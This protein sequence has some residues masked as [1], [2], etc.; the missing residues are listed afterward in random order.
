M[1]DYAVNLFLSSTLTIQC[2]VAVAVTLRVLGHALVDPKVQG[3]HIQDLQLHLN[4]VVGGVALGLT[5]DVFVVP[6]KTTLN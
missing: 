5:Q 2:D 3:G 6:E 4:V 1:Y